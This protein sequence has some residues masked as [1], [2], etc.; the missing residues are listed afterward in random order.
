MSVAT[1]HW[2]SPSKK[3]SHSDAMRSTIFGKSRGAVTL[4]IEPHA[5]LA[6]YH[7]FWQRANSSSAAATALFVAL[8][9]RLAASPAAEG[10]GGQ[11]GPTSP[12]QR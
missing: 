5:T 9:D 3:C 8:A 1:P 6:S 7:S 4:D 10:E 2:K 11:R 12:A